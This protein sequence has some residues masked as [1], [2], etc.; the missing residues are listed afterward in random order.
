MKYLTTLALTFLLTVCALAAP[1][2]LDAT[3]G[4][5]NTGIVTTPI[6]PNSDQI[7]GIAVQAD[8][9]IVAAGWTDVSDFSDLRIVV[10][11]YNA[12]GTVDIT[13]GSSGFAQ[14]PFGAGSAVANC[15][16]IQPDGKIL[17]GGTAVA[18]A[19]NGIQSA[20][21]LVI[22]LDQNGVLDN[23][24]DT[25]GIATTNI[26]PGSFT[27][28]SETAYAMDLMTDG[29]I[30]VSGSYTA[31][32][33]ASDTVIARYNANGSLDTTLGATGWVATS[34]STTTD[35]SNAVRVQ[36]DGKIVSAGFRQQSGFNDSVILRYNADGTPDS[37]F[38]GAGRVITNISSGNFSNQDQFT[39][40]VLQPDGKIIAG[41][42]SSDNS[43]NYFDLV[44]YNTNGSLDASF[45]GGIVQTPVGTS[46]GLLYSLALLPSGRIMA[47]GA[48]ESP[49]GTV[50]MR[51]ARYDTAGVLD[52]SFGSAGMVSTPFAGGTAVI[53]SMAIQPDGKIVAGGCA[54]D[55]HRFD[56]A[57]LRYLSA[58]GPSAAQVS[59]DGRVTTAN[60][61][62]IAK[63]ALTIE[64][65][66]TGASLRALTNQFGF[67]SFT[68][69]PVGSYFISVSAK[70]RRFSPPN[71]LVN[72]FDDLTGE[73][74]TEAGP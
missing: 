70:G 13:F 36:P 57:V 65:P 25:D 74:F 7:Q 2:D 1:G 12:D 28:S 5:S 17:V 54:S 67:Y 9:K 71:R 39:S 18:T 48:G 20:D 26:T 53:N 8:G 45:S 44:R 34:V 73:D 6:G 52:P 72:A 56:F 23:S 60:G 59:I 42:Y 30:V 50:E 32:G 46:N 43:N 4:P 33:G 3:F 31:S 49:T 29:R 64:N 35:L 15:V 19:G 38:G 62:G 61:R 47:A 40:L 66:Q 41:G 11:R 24:F 22:R 68:G 51:I 69:L 21:L 27:N 63:V 10:T 14:F 58:A 37:S 55:G 16:A